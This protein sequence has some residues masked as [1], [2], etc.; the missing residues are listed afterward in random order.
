MRGLQLNHVS[1]RGQ[2][3]HYI[4]QNIISSKLTRI[5][6]PVNLLHLYDM[7]LSHT[8]MIALFHSDKPAKCVR[9][10]LI[11]QAFSFHD[12]HH[13]SICHWYITCFHIQDLHNHSTALRRVCILRAP[14][15]RYYHCNGVW[16]PYD[17]LLPFY[18]YWAT[19]KGKWPRYH[20][21]ESKQSSLPYH[22]TMRA[23]CAQIIDRAYVYFYIRAQL[24]I[25]SQ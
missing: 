13:L 15:T 2:R 17:Y 6:S 18:M 20:R 7:L 16:F 19:T 1:K 12:L 5:F 14:S 24:N 25:F 23:I 11:F 9:G 22:L 10:I 4:Q 8:A 21:S 3:T